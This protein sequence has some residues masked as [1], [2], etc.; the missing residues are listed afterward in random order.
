MQSNWLR[1]ES[2]SG[3]CGSAV[4]MVRE[5]KE[6][7]FNKY[8]MYARLLVQKI[9]L[10]FSDQSLM[11]DICV[12]FSC[13]PKYSFL[14][15]NLL[16]FPLL[17]LP[18]FLRILGQTF[19]YSTVALTPHILQFLSQRSCFCC[20]MQLKLLLTTSCNL[21]HLRQNNYTIS[22]CILCCLCPQ[23][24]LEKGGIMT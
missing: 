17:F 6:C 24:P 3:G 4:N 13:S 10:L 16:F 23:M 12:S 9:A 15:E 20:L 21:L 18:Y 8:C 22:V 11:K 14:D 2:R 5:L 1:L 19:R 7:Y